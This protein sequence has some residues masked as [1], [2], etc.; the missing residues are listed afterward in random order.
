MSHAPAPTAKPL[1]VPQALAQA[2]EL[3]RQGRLA[4]AEQLYA[5][6]LTTRPDHF[7]A[8]HMLGVVKLAQGQPAEALRLVA[9]AM[10]VKAPSPQ[11]LLNH[12]LVLNA[13]N[14]HQEALDNFD[15]AIKRKSKFAE[16]H[17]NRGAVL[18]VL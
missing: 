10:R 5:S 16:A 6:I 9:E 13:L 12:G 17:V 8:L 14:R 18:A 15:L 1:N 4:Q 7:D 2:L 3:H 11:I